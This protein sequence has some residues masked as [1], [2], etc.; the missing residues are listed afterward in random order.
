MPRLV[1]LQQLLLGASAELWL[2]TFNNTAFGGALASS[3]TT[4]NGISGSTGVG[5]FQSAEFIGTLAAPTDQGDASLSFAADVDADVT[6]LRVWVADF[7]VLDAKQVPASGPSRGRVEGVL[8]L[9]PSITGCGRPMLFRA[10]YARAC[11]DGAHRPGWLA[12]KWRLGASSAQGGIASSE[13]V[14]PAAAFSPTLSS[15]QQQREAMRKRLYEPAVPWQTYVHSSMAA[16][17]LQPTGLVLRF[18]AADVGG[19][20]AADGAAPVVDLGPE[21]HISPWPRF[22][23]A[24]VLPGRHSLNGSDY[25]AFE[26]RGWGRAAAGHAGP[27]A[28]RNASLTFE[29]TTATAS[30]GA[31][32]GTAAGRCDLLCVVTCHGADCVDLALSVSGSFE[33]GR[34]GDV[35]LAGGADGAD[36]AFRAPGFPAVTAFAATGSAPLL[37]RAAVGGARRLLRFGGWGARAG[38]STG[39]RRGIGSMVAAIAAARQRAN[40]VPPHLAGAAELALPMFDV[41]AWNTL[42]TTSLHVYTPVSRNW[43]GGSDDAAT[44]FVWD[45][46]FA[47]VMLGCAGAG[48]QRAADIAYANVITTTYSRTTTGMVPNYRSGIGGSTCTCKCAARAQRPL[49]A[50]LVAVVT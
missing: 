16:H 22:S 46:F 17:T 27:A 29:T 44:T 41:L 34:S 21:G 33:W 20:T 45:V 15:A 49:V 3:G 36:L 47:A 38:V 8:A 4:T 28:R 18:G 12:L 26:V 10:H 13:E 9:P 5:C 24:H 25:T 32:N 37:R 42:F 7:L 14:V 2:G 40:V 30:G 48:H 35:S 50:A 6:T 19:A 43:A 11:A 31:C 23:P 39:Q 1:L